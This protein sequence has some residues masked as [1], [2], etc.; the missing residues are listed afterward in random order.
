GRLKDLRLGTIRLILRAGVPVIPCGISGAYD[1]WPRWSRRIQRGTV[2]IRFGRPL[3]FPQLVDRAARDAALPD[4][5]ARL[6]DALAELS[7]AGPEA[8]R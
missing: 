4:A 7:G 2:R 3:R 8:E 5:R 1:V 6:S